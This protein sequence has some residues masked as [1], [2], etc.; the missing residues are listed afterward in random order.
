MK[1]IQIKKYKTY[2]YKGYT[3][4]IWKTANKS[5]IMDSYYSCHLTN[6]KYLS[7]EGKKIA[8]Y[9]KYI[10]FWDILSPDGYSFYGFLD[11]LPPVFCV[12]DSYR[13]TEEECLS[14]A[15][16]SIDRVIDKIEFEKL[17]IKLPTHFYD[18]LSR[19]VIS[20]DAG[21][22]KRYDPETSQVIFNYCGREISISV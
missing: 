1:Y 4:A 9:F 2:D 12:V 3:I 21:L 17:E 16:K 14:L 13:P 5:F 10:Y 7:E 19:K 22:D 11:E 18:P 6:S 15:K 20:M 8:L